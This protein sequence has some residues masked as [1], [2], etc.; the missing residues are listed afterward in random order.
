MN[1]LHFALID[2]WRHDRKRQLG[3]AAR[4]NPLRIA[5]TEALREE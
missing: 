1:A 2:A 5:P 4:E 3:D